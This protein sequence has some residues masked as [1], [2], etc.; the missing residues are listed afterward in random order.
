MSEDLV[1]DILDLFRLPIV[2]LAFGLFAWWMHRGDMKALEADIA[3]LE[4]ENKARKAARESG[5]EWV[6]E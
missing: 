4:K 5:R 1:C 3:R 2:F 6:E